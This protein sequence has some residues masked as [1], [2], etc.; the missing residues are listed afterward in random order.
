MAVIVISVLV[1]G[2]CIG[3]SAW[4]WYDKDEKDV[5]D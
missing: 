4:Y 2:A 3:L 5:C 1:A